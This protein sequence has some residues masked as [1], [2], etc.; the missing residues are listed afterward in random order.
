MAVQTATEVDVSDC[1]IDSNSAGTTIH[2]ATQLRTSP[3]ARQVY[4]LPPAWQAL[5][6]V[7]ATTVGIG[8]GAHGAGGGLCVSGAAAANIQTNSLT[9]NKGSTGGGLFT[10]ADCVAV[11]GGCLMGQVN[12]KDL[13]ASDNSATEAGGVL[14]I[15][16]PATVIVGFA[17]QGPASAPAEQRRKQFLQQLSVSN[18]VAK[19]GYGPAMASFPT[20]LSLAF[21]GQ[22]DVGVAASNI[23]ATKEAA[24]QRWQSQQQPKQ[25]RA[26]RKLQQVP[27]PP[28]SDSVATVAGTTKD[29]KRQVDTSYK[30][31]SSI[32]TGSGKRTQQ[33]AGC[34]RAWP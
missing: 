32:K 22:D 30:A 27:V 34:W 25:G 20:T 10:S 2:D 23:Q 17:E 16:T 8:C 9:G 19:G 4:A 21:S 12:V 3:I 26:G 14:Y 29:I 15:T 5:Y 6:G 18:T 28:T 24:L 33:A 13:T 7:D 31:V 11:A 1:K